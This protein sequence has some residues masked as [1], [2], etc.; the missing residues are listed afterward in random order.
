VAH[1]RNDEGMTNFQDARGD[2]DSFWLDD[3]TSFV[4]EE[5][6]TK[7]VYDLEERTARFGEAVIDFAKTIPQGPTTNRIMSQLVGTGT[8]VGANYAEA[9]DS[10]SKKE[11][12][13]C[14]GTCKK[15]AR[16]TKHFL[17][18]A[19]RPVPELKSEARKLW[20]EARELHLIFSKIWRSGKNK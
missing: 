4:R 2:E 10:V 13:K 1:E 18:M 19:V 6:D 11:F 9:D 12:L 5:P 3:E 8:S 17:R 15:E 14:V 7:R 20:M 16:E